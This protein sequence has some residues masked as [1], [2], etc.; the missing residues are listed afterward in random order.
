MQPTIFR[1]TAAL[2]WSCIWTRMLSPLKGACQNVKEKGSD[3]LMSDFWL[4]MQMP[5]LR[6]VRK[7]SLALI[8]LDFLSLA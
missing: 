8:S 7:M 2:D 1:G 3:T 6:D 4:N 5:P